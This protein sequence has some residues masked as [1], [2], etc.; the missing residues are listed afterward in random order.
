MALEIFKLS[1][2][3]NIFVDEY[4]VKNGKGTKK[5]DLKG[6]YSL[7]KNNGFCE[8]KKEERVVNDLERFVK[9]LELKKAI[10]F[11]RLSEEVK[12]RK[13]SEL[14]FEIGAY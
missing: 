1:N 4:S 14:F 9:Y 3:R 2:S 8:I 7:I 5:Y 13:I 12:Q 11:S 10:K 6:L